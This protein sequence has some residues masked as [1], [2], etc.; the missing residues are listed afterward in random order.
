MNE[1]NFPEVK[2]LSYFYGFIFFFFFFFSFFL[3][4]LEIG[5][6]PTKYSLLA[7]FQIFTSIVY[8]L[9]CFFFHSTFY[10]FNLVYLS[11]SKS[12]PYSIL[13]SCSF[14]HSSHKLNRR[15]SFFLII[16]SWFNS[17]LIILF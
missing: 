12:F 8:L 4:Y 14:N 16:C 15:V 6:H 3:C 11:L 2:L 17:F 13:S 7:R 10:F 1:H 9:N 5:D